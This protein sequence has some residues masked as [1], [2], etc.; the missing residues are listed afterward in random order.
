MPTTQSAE[1]RKDAAA[2]LGAVSSAVHPAK[3]GVAQKV[4][5]V[6]TVLRLAKRYPVAA[7]VVGGLGLA[8][9]MGRRRATQPVLRH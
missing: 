1:T 7:L 9:Y 8:V 4:T 6:S 3:M 2:T 5:V